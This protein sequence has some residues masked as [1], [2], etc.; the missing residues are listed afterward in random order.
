MLKIQMLEQIVTKENVV[1]DAKID[2][3]RCKS[4]AAH[5]RAASLASS[6]CESTK[7]I[8]CNH[9][10]MSSSINSTHLY[11]NEQFLS[12]LRTMTRKSSGSEDDD[13]MGMEELSCL[14]RHTS[15]IL[16]KPDA[17]YAAT[18]DL[19]E[20]LERVQC[21]R[22]DDQRCALQVWTLF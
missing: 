4:L 5:S 16:E 6:D 18:Q 11:S 20:L 14:G 19:F 22:F 2:S 12:R 21:S 3:E 15:G 7:C 17:L 9:Q 10:L 1:D 13:V 8:K